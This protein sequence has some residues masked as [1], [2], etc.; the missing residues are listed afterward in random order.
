M[1][2][3]LI[4]RLN[5]HLRHIHERVGRL[6]FGVELLCVAGDGDG[7]GEGGRHRRSGRSGRRHHRRD[8]EVVHV[9]LER[10]VGRHRRRRVGRRRTVQVRHDGDVDRVAHR[11]VGRKTGCVRVEIVAG[12]LSI[13]N[14]FT[15]S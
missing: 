12:L 15:K 9:L 11:V 7:G 8:G 6:W 3:I 1:Y 14:E 5:V 13:C 10:R 2:V 4:H